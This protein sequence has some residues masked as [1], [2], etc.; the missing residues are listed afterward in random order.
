[1]KWIDTSNATALISDLLPT[2]VGQ[3]RAQAFAGAPSPARLISPSA[4]P[5]SL[6]QVTGTAGPLSWIRSSL[7]DDSLT[8]Q[9]CF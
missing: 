8:L 1:M 6:P 9:Q 3:R 7:Q 2:L 5:D 4:G